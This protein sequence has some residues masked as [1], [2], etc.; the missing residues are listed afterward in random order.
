VN[1]YRQSAITPLIGIENPDENETAGKDHGSAKRHWIEFE[2]LACGI[3]LIFSTNLAVQNRILNK[4]NK[5]GF[6]VKPPQEKVF[7]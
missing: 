7:A 5:S 1:A 2:P 4:L 3:D 6:V